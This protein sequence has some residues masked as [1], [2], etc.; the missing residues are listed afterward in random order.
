MKE[1]V[2]LVV[3]LTVICIVA[4][5]SLSEVYTLTKDP[6]EK[7]ARE[8]KLSAMRAIV[9]GFDNEPDVDT[10]TTSD[11]TDDQGNEITRTYYLAKKEGEVIAV[12]F[13]SSSGAGYGG[14]ITVIVGVTPEGA[15][16][17]V[18][19]LKHSETPGLGTK[20]AKPEWLAEFVGRTLDN[21][22]WA[23]TKDGGDID[24]TSGATISPR[25]V[26]AAVKEGL[27]GFLRHKEEILGEPR[28]LTETAQDE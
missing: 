28:G 21:T 2:R 20:V 5:A 26:V 27:D 11:G 24:Y 23:V 6:I 4:A 7:A 17:G 9:P 16:T 12:L 10:V 18:Q 8:E 13:E 3:V 14:T 15:I 1:I 25:A 19:V 22:K